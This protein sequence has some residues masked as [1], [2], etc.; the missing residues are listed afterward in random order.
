MRNTDETAPSAV[1]RARVLEAL[2]PIAAVDG[3]TPQAIAKAAEA[4][5]VAP[6]M[7]ELAA[8]RGVIDWL[9]AFA[10]WA[11]DAMEAN[12]ADTDLLSRKIRERVKMAVLAR[13]DALEPHKATAK[14]A[15]HAFVV[16]G[17]APEAGKQLWRT[18]DRI[19]R[20][21]G[22]Q[23]TDGNFYS[24][25]AILSAVVGSVMARWL[26]DDS[27][28]RAAT[29]A[30]LDARIANVMQFETL[31]AR[32]KPLAA[33]GEEAVARLARWRYGVDGDRA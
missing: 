15:A 1:A 29:E 21:L 20:L 8:P 4:A 33:L 32:A 3:F 11:D 28:N 13:L 9:D 10:L 23:S 27:G 5:G 14:R 19:W 17:R 31:K 18:A 2:L 16:P 26:A 30:F 12:L 25:R 24:K 22:D 6:G 7:V